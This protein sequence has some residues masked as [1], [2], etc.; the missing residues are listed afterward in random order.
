MSVQQLK[1]GMGLSSCKP[2]IVIQEPFMS[3][4]QLEIKA[5]LFSFEHLHSVFES[6]GNPEESKGR[7]NSAWKTFEDT[8]M[9][10]EKLNEPRAQEHIMLHIIFY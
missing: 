4:S 5:S 1:M 10:E 6:Q 9:S 2:K 8:K 7:S 3:I